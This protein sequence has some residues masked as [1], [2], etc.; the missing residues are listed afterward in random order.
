M[1][2]NVKIEQQIHK[3]WAD[4]DFL[5]LIHCLVQQKQ[6]AINRHKTFFGPKQKIRVQLH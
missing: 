4:L 6:N 2:K 5:V 1:S 3:I